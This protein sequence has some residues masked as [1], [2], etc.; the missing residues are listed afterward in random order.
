MKRFMKLAR[1]KI[2]TVYQK[3]PLRWWK[4]LPQN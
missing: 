3:I 2:R 1:L 4:G